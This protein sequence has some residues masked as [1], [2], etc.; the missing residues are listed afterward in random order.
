MDWLCNACAHHQWQTFSWPTAALSCMASRRIARPHQGQL[1]NYFDRIR[2]RTYHN[3]MDNIMQTLFLSLFGHC[4]D[5]VT[6]MMGK[7]KIKKLDQRLIRIRI[8]FKGCCDWIG[9]VSASLLWCIEIINRSQAFMRP[10]TV[11]PRHPR[12]YLHCCNCWPS[13]QPGAEDEVQRCDPT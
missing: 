5:D 2:F 13:V 7:R 12:R 10:A 6:M 3:T 1:L 11:R 4:Y 8:Y 9:R